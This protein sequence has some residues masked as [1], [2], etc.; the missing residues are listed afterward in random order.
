MIAWAAIPQPRSFTPAGGRLLLADVTVVGGPGCEREAER[1]RAELR[2][3]GLTTPSGSAPAGNGGTIISLKLDPGLDTIPGTIDAERAEIVV[4]MDGVRIRAAAGVGLFRATRQILHNV[5]A[6]G[7]VPCGVAWVAPAVAER[8]LHLDAAR[9]FF[10]ARWIKDELRRA[11]DVGVNAFQ[12]HFSENEGF[13]LENPGHP[14]VMSAHV[15]TRAE[16]AEIIELARDLHIFVIPSLD[17]PGHLRKVLAEHPDLQLP[18][19]QRPA[20][21]EPLAIPDTGHALNIAEPAALDFAHALI[22]DMADVFAG[23]HAWNLGGDEFVDFAHIEAYSGLSRAARE[24]FGPDATGFDLL[25]ATVN[26]IADDVAARGFEPRV[27]NDGMFRARLVRLDPRVKVTWWT[28]WH[29]EMAPVNVALGEGHGVVNFNDALFYY[30][31]GENA[32][33]CYPTAAR[34]WEA[35]WHPGLFPS[36]PGG[37]RQEIFAGER[38]G[39]RAAGRAGE[40]T[41]AAATAGGRA[42]IG[43]P[44]DGTAV[45]GEI[46]RSGYP[47]QLVGAYFSVWAD[48]PQAQSA[49]EVSDGIRPGLRALAERSFNAGSKLTLD[50]FCE[51]DA[52]IGVPGPAVS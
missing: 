22:N 50:E 7:Y 42:D 13:R 29:A 14:E 51:L 24:R 44:A 15:I 32:G 47:A 4:T 18:A 38:V 16:A 17:M 37:H 34:V 45:G 1:L 11:A 25:T 5:R 3:R 2:E 28:N 33:Y 23:C 43:E 39:A 19:A 48:K 27:W 6:R 21:A 30:V 10:S 9:K 41:G 36:L 46:S 12:W 31:L 26:E 35:D 49:R 20:D 40:L 52:A 8:G